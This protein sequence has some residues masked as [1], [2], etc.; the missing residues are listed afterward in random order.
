[1]T[2]QGSMYGVAEM[3]QRA[4]NTI[5]HVRSELSRIGCAPDKLSVQRR[6]PCMMMTYGGQ[7]IYCDPYEVMILLRGTVSDL[8]EAQVWERIS[9]KVC[10]TQ[11]Q[12]SGMGGWTIIIVST[13]SILLLLKT[14]N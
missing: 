1:M 2:G 7:T 5:L 13:I 8:D 10:V 12:S 6:G 3:N 4:E 14:L 11:Q 9:E